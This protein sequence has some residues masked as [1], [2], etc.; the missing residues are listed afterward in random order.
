MKRLMFLVALGLLLSACASWEI[1][2]CEVWPLLGGCD[3]LSH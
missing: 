3:F 2:R 1:L